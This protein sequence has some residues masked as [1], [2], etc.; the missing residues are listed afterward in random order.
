MSVVPI[1]GHMV[2]RRL[3][4]TFLAAACLTHGAAGQTKGSSLDTAYLR[5]HAQTRG[6]MLGRPVKP[7]PTPDGKAVLFLRSASRSPKLS[8]YEFDTATRKTRELLSPAKLVKGAEEKLSPEEKALRERMR[9]SLGGF[10]TFQLSENGA[11]VLLPFS[12]RLYVYDRVAD[13]VN[14][15]AT[16]PGSLFDPRLS[17][18]GTKVAFVRDYDI[19]VF[20]LVGR[21]ETQ[22]TFKGTQEVPHGLAE[23]VAQEE[24]GRFTGYWWSPDSKHILFQ[25]SDQKEVEVWYVADPIQPGQKPTPFYYPRPGKKNVEVRL[26]VASLEGE[27]AG[28]PRWLE[29]ERS[30]YPYVT[31]VHW[32]KHGP[33]LVCVQTRSQDEIAVLKADPATG[34][35]EVLFTESDSAWVN[36]HQ[37]VPRWLPEGKGLLW[38]GERNGGPQLEWR[39]PNGRL[40]RVLVPVSDGFQSVA[41]VSFEK[42]RAEVLYNASADPTQSHVFR[43]AW[44][45]WSE[46]VKLSKETGL[47]A[48]AANRD[49][50][51][52]VIT[53][54]TLGSMPFSTVHWPGGAAELP[55]VAEQEPFD[56]RVEL[57]KVGARE[58][59]AAVLVP[60]QFDARKKYPVLVDVY[61][62]PHHLH[63]LAAKNRWLLDQWYADQGFIVVALDG[64]GTPGRG[65]AWERAIAGKFGS[66]PLE[67]QVEGLQALAQKFPAMDMK[68]VGIDG[69]SFG[70]YMAALAVM[71]RPDI[72]K[73][74]VAGA[75]VCDWYD[76][77]THY[78][79]RYLGVPPKAEAAYKEGSL[80]TYAAD[81]SRPLLI[82]H[83][84]AD[85]NVY[86]RHSLRLVDALFRHGKNFEMVPL[87]GLTHMVPDP[88]VMERLH[89]RIAG[90]L[91]KHL[92]APE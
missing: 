11:L 3:V 8:L 69:W 68:R 83:G 91:K 80:L 90:F 32:S 73:V 53:S 47:H 63:V 14:E 66:L 61:G 5:E 6:F 55:A 20:D 60:R 27:T 25:E 62:G 64:R 50:Q 81:L 72:F 57:L 13:Q 44:E 77:D 31:T 43:L 79:E 23:F 7:V 51:T 88:T 2:R 12:G 48:L 17:P 35:T 84:T 87:S 19:H 34:K 86:F 49:H 40:R 15:L 92:G 52:Y 29:W 59:H 9:Q 54:R 76:Y 28:P 16:R 4:L 58:F 89:E 78:T 26:G 36:I 18:D 30:R 74:G 45:E 41:S 67:D 22:V 82:L 33:P 1:L 39:M 56:P 42:N 65:R 46:P 70:G 21:K 10:T 24:M 85:D 75:P 38:V 37:G 71:R